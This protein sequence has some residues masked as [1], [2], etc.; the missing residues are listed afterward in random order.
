MAFY[1]FCICVLLQVTFSYIYPVRHTAESEGLYWKSITE[2]LREKGWKGIG[3]YKLLSI[4]LLAVMCVLF[5][6][7]R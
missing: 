5:W 7:F 2:P 6:V 3:N 1:L 4:A